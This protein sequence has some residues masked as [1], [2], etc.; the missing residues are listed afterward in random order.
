IGMTDDQ[1]AIGSVIAVVLALGR[2]D[3]T[4]LGS[5]VRA[6]ILGTA[7]LTT[8]EA[9]LLADGST[10]PYARM[11]TDQT[12]IGPGYRIF[13]C[14]DGWIAVVAPTDEARA[15]VRDVAGCTEDADVP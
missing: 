8:S 4:G 13:A 3:R 6:S 15:R 14:P 2:R 11:D 7:L 1:C 5:D 12:G 10:A 9:M